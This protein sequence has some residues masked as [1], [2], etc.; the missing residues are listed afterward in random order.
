[1]NRHRN[2]EIE[3]DTDKWSDKRDAKK[4]EDKLGEKTKRRQSGRTCFR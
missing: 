1:M 4:K 3:E 2:R